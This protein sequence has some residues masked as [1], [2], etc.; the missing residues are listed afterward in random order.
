[1]VSASVSSIAFLAFGLAYLFQ[2]SEQPEFYNYAYK[3]NEQVN[4]A[5]NFICG[6]DF[7]TNCGDVVHL[8]TK[9]NQNIRINL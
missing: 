1:M 9:I 7:L 8:P 6:N 2:I 4:H 5:Y 3:E